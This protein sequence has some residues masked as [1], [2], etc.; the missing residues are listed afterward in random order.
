MSH[1]F[2]NTNK[3]RI[4]ND[5]QNHDNQ[6]SCM[7]LCI[8]REKQISFLKKDFLSKFHKTNGYSNWFSC[9]KSSSQLFCHKEKRIIFVLT[10]CPKN[11]YSY[12]TKYMAAR[13]FTVSYQNFS[14]K[15]KSV[16][17]IVLKSIKWS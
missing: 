13:F 6:N 5:F 17:Q 4:I 1:I 12:G 16:H 2:R 14:Q 15:S 8:N 11:W 9:K 10:P 3:I 7:Y